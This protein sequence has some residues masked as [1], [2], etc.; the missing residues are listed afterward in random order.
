[1]ATKK[2]EPR[3]VDLEAREAWMLSKAIDEY[4]QIRDAGRKANERIQAIYAGILSRGGVDVNGKP[5]GWRIEEGDDAISLVEV[6]DDG[7]G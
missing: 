1:M 5:G 4:E 6:L 3:R 2:D 7:A